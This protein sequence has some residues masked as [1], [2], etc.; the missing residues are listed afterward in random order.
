MVIEVFLE[1]QILSSGKSGLGRE[2][3]RNRKTKKL[4]QHTNNNALYIHNYFVKDAFCVISQKSKHLL[5]G[6]YQSYLKDEG[7]WR[8][9]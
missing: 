5:L 3:S 2:D 7:S 1:Y 8:G 4:T 9:Q 6:Y